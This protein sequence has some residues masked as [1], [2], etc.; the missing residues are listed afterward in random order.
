MAEALKSFSAPMATIY[1]GSEAVGVAQ[2]VS[3]QERVTQTPVRGLGSLLV[4]EFVPTAID[5]R[6][7]W[8]YI[9]ISLDSSWFKKVSNRVGSDPTALV[10][11]FSL[12]NPSFTLQV[13]RK[14]G[15]LNADRLVPE[16]DTELVL[17]ALDCVVEN[18]SWQLAV[19]GI[20][21]SNISG[22]YK[23]PMLKS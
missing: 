23:T 19:G 22:R 7:T 5:C 3:F 16:T 21:A 4:D 15:E 13:D 10:N 14:T 11:A 8:E 18:T 12:Y 6:F 20:C 2:Q 1:I 9:F 17:K